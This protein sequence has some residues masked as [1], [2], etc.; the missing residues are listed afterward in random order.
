MKTKYLIGNMKMNMSKEK[1]IPYFEGLKKI[2][3]NSNNIVGVCVPSVYLCLAEKCLNG[4]KVK[5]GVENFYY[6]DNG[7]YTGEIS[8]EMLKDFNTELVIVGHSERRTLFGETDADVNLKTK[9]ALLSGFRPIVCFGE[10]LD[11]RNRH[12]EKLVV[13]TQILEA[14]QDIDKEDIKKIIFAYEPVWAI[15]TGVTATSEQAEE[16]IS[17]AKELIISN[18]EGLKPEDIIMLYGGSMKGSN[19]EDL[20]SKPSIDGGLIG[21]ACLNV[22]DFKKII[23]IEIK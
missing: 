13:Q 20:L 4:S 2:A 22:E 11:E 8:A 17:Y 15:G 9:K 12:F 18:Y 7:A 21:G 14:I 3:E 5:Y 19:A 1:L 23:D 16:I 10:N 6:K